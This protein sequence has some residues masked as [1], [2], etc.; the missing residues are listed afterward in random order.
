MTPTTGTDGHPEVAEIS[1]LAE[2]IL[3]PERLAGVRGHIAA[4]ALCADVRA[5]LDEI[6]GLLGT[7]PGPSRM[8]ADIAGRIDA[9]LAAEALLASSGA[10]VSRVSRVSRETRAPEPLPVSRE[11]AQTEAGRPSG[12][13][14]AGS[15]PGRPAARSRRRWGK[16]LLVAASLAAVVGLGSFLAQSGWTTGDSA[17]TTRSSVASEKAPQADADT[18]GSQV[19][20]LLTAAMAR[21]SESKPSGQSPMA[22]MDNAV[23]SCVLKAVDRREPPIAVHRGRY[24]GLDSYLLVLPHTGDSSL[25]DAYVVD[26]SCTGVRPSATGTLLREETYPR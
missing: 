10:A 2:G 9:A 3:P 17:D 13:G 25:V 12:R 1:A 26:A 23:P 21:R 6:R 14:A 16:G 22:G 24:E 19:H 20:E 5:S 8:P 15:G 11:T 18:L 7:L 4:C